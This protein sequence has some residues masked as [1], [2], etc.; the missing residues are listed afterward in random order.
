MSVF[1][2]ICSK[3]IF[4]EARSLPPGWFMCGTGNIKDTGDASSST[5]VTA[6]HLNKQKYNTKCIRLLDQHGF[7][8]QTYN[9]QHDRNMCDNN[10]EQMKSYK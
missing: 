2:S 8:Q 9:I 1:L 4:P 10:N 6:I 5:E 7:A 3:V